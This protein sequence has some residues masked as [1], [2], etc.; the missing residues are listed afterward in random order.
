MRSAL[1]SYPQYFSDGVHPN[2]AG[3][4][5]IARTVHTA[6]AR[7][8]NVTLAAAPSGALV[9][10]TATPTAAY[11]RVERVAFYDGPTKL[12]E[13]TS[14]PWTFTAEAVNEGTHAYVAEVTETAGRTARSAAETVTVTAPPPGSASSPNA[15]SGS[16][17]SSAPA[18]G[19]AAPDRTPLIPPPSRAPAEAR[20]EGD[21][22]CAFAAHGGAGSSSLVVLAA[23]AHFFCARRRQR[24][25]SSSTSRKPACH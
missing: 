18:D 7:Q 24:S 17:P 23:L 5:L 1:A 20:P 8:P 25:A 4:D 12:G 2:D 21:A 10:L 3:A 13:R 6:I 11:G 22:G 14:A 15:S 19:I 16:A 9:A